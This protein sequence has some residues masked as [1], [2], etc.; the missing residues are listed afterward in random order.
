MRAPAPLSPLRSGVA[1]LLAGLV[2]ALGL[3][4]WM[5]EVHA[6]LHHPAAD[7]ACSSAH[8]DASDT[9]SAPEGEHGCVVTLFA[10]GLPTPV[11][12]PVALPPRVLAETTLPTAPE[13]APAAAPDRLHPPALAPPAAV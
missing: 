4:A 9:H 10:Q 11:A 5:P 2:F 12:A 13:S 8:K 1:A 7:Q 3:L 6:R